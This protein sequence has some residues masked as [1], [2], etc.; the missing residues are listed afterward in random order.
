MRWPG[1]LT[2]F[3]IHSLDTV[4]LSFLRQRGSIGLCGWSSPCLPQPTLPWQS[5]RFSSWTLASRNRRSSTPPGST[6]TKTHSG[7][8][9]TAAAG[10]KAPVYCGYLLLWVFLSVLCVWM[11]AIG[12][13]GNPKFKFLWS[14][15]SNG[16]SLFNF[17]LLFFLNSAFTCSKVCLCCN[18]SAYFDNDFSKS[19]AFRV[20][21]HTVTPAEQGAQHAL[22]VLRYEF[23]FF[24]FWAECVNWKTLKERN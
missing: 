3:F 8:N 7:T 19:C 6:E 4:F 11:R 18:D 21:S 17:S 15:K 2:A 13:S 23:L 12:F 1:S 5:E 22:F 24:N 10:C 9:W 14:T 20:P 16:L